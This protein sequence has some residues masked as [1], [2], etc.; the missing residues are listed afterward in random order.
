[1]TEL[2]EEQAIAIYYSKIYEN[3]TDDEIVKFQ[4]FT[5]RLCMPF[6][7]FHEAVEH[8]LHRPVWT[9]EFIDTMGLQKEYLGEKDAPTFEEIISLIPENKRFIMRI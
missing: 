4:L 3:W 9:T 7:K 2:T 1:M 6:D 5:E 8:I